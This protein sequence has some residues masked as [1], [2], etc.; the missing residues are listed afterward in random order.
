MVCQ[1]DVVNVKLINRIL[2]GPITN[3][4]GSPNST[5]LHFHGIR[6]VGVKNES[7]GKP[8]EGYEDYGPWSDGVPF[9]NQCPVPG[10]LDDNSSHHIF[11]YTFRA[12]SNPN[13]SHDDFN[14]PPGTYWYHSHVGAQRTNGL[15]GALIIKEKYKKLYKNLIDQPRTQTIIVQEWYE[16]PTIQAACSTLHSHWSIS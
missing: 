8:V 16:S 9:V 14:A 10:K 4:D 15:Q 6:E 12:G 7:T 1:N 5:T 2:D 13:I 11:H 3:A